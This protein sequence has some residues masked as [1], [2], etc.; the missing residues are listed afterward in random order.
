M[1]IRIITTPRTMSSETMRCL[2][3]M[4]RVSARS[5]RTPSMRTRT[6]PSAGRT[7]GGGL[8]GALADRRRAPLLRHLP[9]ALAQP[10][11][12]HLVVEDLDQ[13]VAEVDGGARAHRGGQPRSERLRRRQREALLGGDDHVARVHQPRHFAR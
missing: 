13:L 1:A 7:A 4:T 9:P 2:S 3:A 11:A 5:R 10:F 8:L 12:Q 6:A